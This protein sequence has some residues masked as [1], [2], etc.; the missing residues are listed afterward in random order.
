MFP[1]FLPFAEVPSKPPFVPNVQRVFVKP[2]DWLSLNCTSEPSRP[3]VR[4]DWL[5]N[6]QEVIMK[7][8]HQLHILKNF[9][10]QASDRMLRRFIES[11]VIDEMNQ[12]AAIDNMELT[13]SVLGL[14]FWVKSEHYMQGKLTV[15]CKGEIPSVYSE[16]SDNFIV[17]EHDGPQHKVLQ[18]TSN[19]QGTF[20][21]TQKRPEI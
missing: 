1:S 6:G 20:F 12:K 14:E 19:S 13:Q 5:V 16:E 18:A 8:C 3:P 7:S 11:P 9:N 4:L 17:G 2:G 10:L 15:K 21:R